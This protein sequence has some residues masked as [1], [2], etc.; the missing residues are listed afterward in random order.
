[1][2]PF[3]Y[4]FSK[5]LNPV[6]VNRSGTNIRVK[7]N[8]NRKTILLN[9]PPGKVEY[10][11]I[12]VLTENEISTPEEAGNAASIEM[13]TVKAYTFFCVAGTKFAE[14][15]DGSESNPWASVNYAL[16]Q[17]Q[18]IVDCF[19]QTNCCEYIQLRCSGVCNYEVHNIQ[20]DENGEWV[21]STFNGENR[22]ILSG[23]EI[24]FNVSYN[25]I[26]NDE[27]SAYAREEKFIVQGIYESLFDSLKI[28]ASVLVDVSSEGESQT[29][30][31]E[32]NAWGVYN[33]S[34]IFYF[35]D[36]SV[37]T[38]G[39]GRGNFSSS[40]FGE[41][42]GEGIGFFSC[43]GTFIQCRSLGSG[44]GYGICRS[45]ENADKNS[46]AR[47][48]GTGFRQCSGIFYSCTG[49]GEGNAEGN[50]T[51]FSQSSSYLLSGT[52][53]GSGISNC[54]GNF[55][56]CNANGVASA[57]GAGPWECDGGA[58]AYGFTSTSGNFFQC[59]AETSATGIGH[60]DNSA[61]GTGCSVSYGF[62]NCSDLLISCSANAESVASGE[63][64]QCRGCG[65]LNCKAEFYNCSSSDKICEYKG[66][67]NAYICENFE[68]DI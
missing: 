55:Y 20:K 61:P 33:C 49:I 26:A 1:M 57:K 68:C 16:N 50:S 13:K 10:V 25:V 22:F 53:S 11:E 15:G 62:Y 18:P 38:S 29:G 47:A 7:E 48:A 60:Q 34:G 46:E 28:T 45:G 54:S 41:G 36:V 31:A 51:S 35:C 65:F 9:I 3:R 24:N 2:K 32:A 5:L 27:E 12:P 40:S 58:A 52:G 42:Y 37:Y 56:F 30:Y 8:S 19:S 64:F 44:N 67:S 14:G 59:S 66:G 43:T 6:I 21:F 23:L 63:T 4:R 39:T 17:L